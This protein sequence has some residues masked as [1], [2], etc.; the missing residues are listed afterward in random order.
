MGGGRAG[1]QATTTTT[2]T[3]TSN[4][5]PRERE[6]ER[7][8]QRQRGGHGRASRCYRLRLGAMCECRV[9]PFLRCCRDH[10]GYSFSLALSRS[11]LYTRSLA[12]DGGGGAWAWAGSTLHRC[13]ES[14]MLAC[15]VLKQ[16]C[17]TCTTCTRPTPTHYGTL[18]TTRPTPAPRNLRRMQSYIVPKPCRVWSVYPAWPC[19]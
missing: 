18:P 17:A 11:L 1:R 2:R 9:F 12:G 10:D 15:P 13:M 7:E 5:R 3:A 16:Q 4:A 6:R 8:R 14:G 19:T